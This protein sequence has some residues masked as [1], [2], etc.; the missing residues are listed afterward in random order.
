MSFAKYFNLFLGVLWLNIAACVFFRELLPPRVGRLFGGADMALV[1]TLAIL[2]AVYNFVRWW[3]V[4][5]R[6]RRRVT[7]RVHPLASHRDDPSDPYRPNPD[8]D[9]LRVPDADGPPKPSANGD[10]PS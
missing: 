4:M 2:L 9:F 1:G 5:A 3:A 7:F 10:H 8:L 6:E